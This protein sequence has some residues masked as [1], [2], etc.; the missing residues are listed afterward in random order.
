MTHPATIWVGAIVTLAVFS[1]LAKDNPFYRLVQHAALG[2]MVGM[3][4]VVTIQNVLWPNWLK[5][6]VQG[7]NGQGPSL[8]VLWFLALIPGSLWYFQLSKKYFWV[9][10][11]VTG[12]FIGVAAGMAFKYWMLLI[13]PQIGASLKPVN[14]IGADGLTV[15]SGLNALNNL[16][17]I[18]AI[19]TTLLYFFFSFRGE[20]PAA[21]KAMRAGRIVIMICL[22]GMFGSTVMTRLSYLLERLRFLSEDWIR[23]QII[24]GVFG[25]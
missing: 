23:D 20:S 11:F 14:P 6:I 9:S 4:I 3:A 25:G 8:G 7:I 18:V 21:Q 22:G 19:L 15:S 16:V 12:L 13:M 17:F 1:Y 24:R 5:P 2:V 10:R